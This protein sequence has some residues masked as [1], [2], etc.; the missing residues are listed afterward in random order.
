MNHDSKWKTESRKLYQEILS[1]ADS[2]VQVSTLEY[3]QRLM[4]QRNRW[5]V[6][7]ADEVIAVW[8]GNASGTKNCVDYTRSCGKD[9]I[10]INPDGQ[11][12]TRRLSEDK[13]QY[14]AKNIDYTQH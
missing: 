3:E 9:V 1:K 14:G 12:F 6:D 5:M 7:H 4:Q 10:W 11:L 13:Y 2:V 8:N